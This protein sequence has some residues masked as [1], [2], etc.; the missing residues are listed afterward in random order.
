MKFSLALAVAFLPV[1]VN[2]QYG[3]PDPAPSSSSSS[4]PAV[5]SAPASNSSSVNVNVGPGGALTFNPSDFTAA[6]GTTVTFFF[7]QSVPHSVT[8]SSFANPCTYLAAASGASGGF[9]SGL[10]T[11]KQFTI[12]ITNDQ[13]PIWF[14]CKA[15]KHCGLG[16]VGSINAPTTGSNTAAAFLAAAKAIGTNE[17]TV[18]D[19]GPVTGGVNAQATATPAAT[20][21]ASSPASSPS[22]SK[23]A[24]DHL[25]AS[26]VFAFLAA[27]F[28]ITLA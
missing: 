28:G 24:A 9:D 4:S 11:A 23:S 1:I 25:V 8:Q 14:F 16:M 6:N 13:Q 22:T 18:S 2:A 26:G 17:Q 3:A 27:V 5:P 15:S 19:N 21:A 20:F 10:Q 12:K 7:P